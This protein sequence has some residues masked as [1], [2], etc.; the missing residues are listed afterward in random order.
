MMFTLRLSSSVPEVLEHD[1]FCRILQMYCWDQVKALLHHSLQEATAL[2]G[3]RMAL[4][5]VENVGGRRS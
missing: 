2:V 1:L 5:D 4:Q 3:S